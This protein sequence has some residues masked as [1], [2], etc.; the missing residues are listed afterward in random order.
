MF[1]RKRSIIRDRLLL[2]GYRATLL[3]SLGFLEEIDNVPR[4]AEPNLRPS[5]DFPASGSRLRPGQLARDAKL[6]E[7]VGELHEWLV[8]GPTGVRADFMKSLKTKVR[9]ILS[10]TTLYISRLIY[11]KPDYHWS[12]LYHRKPGT[13]RS[14]LLA[15]G[16][17]VGSLEAVGILDDPDRKKGQKLARLNTATAESQ[18]RLQKLVKALDGWLHQG[19]ERPKRTHFLRYL[20]T[21]VRC[22]IVAKWTL[23][24]TET[25]TLMDEPFPSKATLNFPSSTRQ[26]S[27]TGRTE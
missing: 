25:W 11:Q 12:Q 23:T 5:S 22:N 9:L 27:H 15:L 19:E 2:K 8:N 7:L 21:E 1:E 16:H 26:K 17:K 10:P 3:D 4:P 20:A 24:I 18:H 13:I 14:A 6:N